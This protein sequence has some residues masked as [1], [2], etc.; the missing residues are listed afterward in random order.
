MFSYTFFVGDYMDWSSYLGI[1]FEFNGSSHLGCDCIGLL[2]LVWKEKGWNEDFM[3][4]KLVEKKWYEE[5]PYRLL[6]YLCR[7]FDKVREIG[8]LKEGDIL[9]FRINDEGH[10]A[11]WLGYGKYLQSFPPIKEGMISMSHMARFKHIKDSFVCGFRRRESD[12]YAT[13]QA[14]RREKG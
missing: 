1:P 12:Q 11:I 10:V 8:Q 2:R 7:H 5:N 4:G 13:D 14:E 9:Y 3:D 6:R